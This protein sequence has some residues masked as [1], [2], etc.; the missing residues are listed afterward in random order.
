MISTVVMRAWQSK[1]ISGRLL[2]IFSLF[3]PR[4]IHYPKEFRYFSSNETLTKLR[5][6]VESELVD[7]GKSVYIGKSDVV[8]TEFKFL[9]RHYSTRQFYK[10]KE[11][12][13]PVP[14]GWYFYRVGTFVQS[15]KIF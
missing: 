4:H 5:N 3:D 2:E 14:V 1:T 6:R 15:T 13:A 8:E 7:C 12:L 11:I 10:G 9:E